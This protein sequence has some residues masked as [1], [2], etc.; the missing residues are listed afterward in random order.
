MLVTKRLKILFACSQVLKCKS[1]YCEVLQP[2]LVNTK[3]FNA[4]FCLK[5][6]NTAIPSSK[7][8]NQFEL[9]RLT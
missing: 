6:N 7:S 1:L 2:N 8:E 4:K 5:R 3:S 9:I